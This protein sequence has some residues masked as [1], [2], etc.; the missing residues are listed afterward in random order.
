MIPQIASMAIWC[1]KL[2]ETFFV[3]L[4]YAPTFCFRS[5]W[6]VALLPPRERRACAPATSCTSPFDGRA[7][8]LDDRVRALDVWRAAILRISSGR[9][10]PC[11]S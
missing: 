8:A 7:A 5:C 2:D 11:A 9:V 1:P 3:P 10:R 6:N 4:A